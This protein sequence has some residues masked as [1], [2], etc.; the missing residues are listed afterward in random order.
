MRLFRFYFSCLCFSFVTRSSR[1]L[2]SLSDEL[3]KP[4]GWSV[5]VS[6]VEPASLLETFVI[7]D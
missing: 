1:Q 5:L 6:V 4:A 7:K 3:S 2:V